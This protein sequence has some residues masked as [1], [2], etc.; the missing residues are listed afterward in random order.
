MNQKTVEINGTIYD[1]HTG[2]PIRHT[3]KA[4]TKQRSHATTVHQRTQKSTTLHRA[5]VQKKSASNHAAPT[6]QADEKDTRVAVRTTRPTPQVE[7][8]AHIQ[9]YAKHPKTTHTP[10]Q[11][12]RSTGSAHDIIAPASVH[13]MVQHV[14][15]ARATK[16]PAKKTHK[17][18][19][20]IKNEAVTRALDSAPKHHR[21]PH[22]DKARVRS[23]KERAGRAL[24]FASSGAA[25]LLIAGYFTYMNMPNLSVRVAAVQAGVD[26]QYPEFRPSGYSLAG[27]IAYD[28]GSVAMTFDSN[29]TPAN[30]TLTQAKSGWD[31]VAVLENYVAPKAGENYTTTTS[32]GLTVYS[33]NGNA[34]W[35]NDGILYTVDGNAPLSPDQVQ[36]MAAS[37]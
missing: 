11:K 13:P 2:M 23:R 36:R 4:P 8:S 34:A 25:L 21:A 37:L 27:P 1:K 35:V 30:F 10:A 24:T 33:W 32:G 15:A 29:G 7:R 31:S 12:S 6:E 18:S 19:D 3:D 17:P 5:Y 9:K 16:Q 26:A 14:H 20:V 22:R 28:D